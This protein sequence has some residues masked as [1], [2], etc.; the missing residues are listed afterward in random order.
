MTRRTLIAASLPLSNEPPTEWLLLP[1]GE[2]HARWAGGAEAS[3]LVDETA[4][5]AVLT[6][7]QR[8]GHD[9]NLDYNHAQFDGHVRN[10]HEM[11]SAGSFE[12]ELR[13]DG[14]WMVDIRWT[15]DAAG[16]LRRREYRY[17]SPTFDVDED[18]RIVQLHNVALT[19]NP[20]TLGALPL[21]ASRNQPPTGA[22]EET[23]L[24]PTLI[25]LAADTPP[26]QVSAQVLALANFQAAVLERV[27]ATDR[28]AA[29]AAVESLATKAGETEAL[30]QRVTELEA[31]ANEVQ[32]EQLLA[33]AKLD[34]R[35]TPAQCAVDGWA[36]TVQLDVLREFLKTASPVV[37][38]GSHSQPAAEV[39]AETEVE[40]HESFNASVRR[41]A[42]RV[43]SV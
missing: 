14:L 26:A 25:G 13:S 34:G 41:M 6:A 32:R 16:Y 37:P 27:G 21:V 2:L 35:L 8:G 20:A 36:R 43:L 11:R 3:F 12:L 30:T 42:R 33:D 39:E 17:L 1:L 40:P 9:L 23:Q 29:M 38:V 4:A 5:V 22:G 24:D 31:A 15:E 10:D 28:E 19:P 18:G 7:Y